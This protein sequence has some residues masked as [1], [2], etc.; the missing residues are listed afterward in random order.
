MD[1]RM[2]GI[3]WIQRWMDDAVGAEDAPA[4]PSHRLPCP[5]VPFSAVLCQHLPEGTDCERLVGSSAVYRVCFGTAC[6]HLAQAALLL[7]VRSSAGRRAQIHNGYGDRDRHR[8]RGWA[9]GAAEGPVTLALAAPQMLAPEAAGA[10]GALCRQLLPPRGRLHPRCVPHP[11]Q[12]GTLGTHCAPCA[13]PTAALS[14]AWHYTGVCGGFAFILI[15]LVLITAFAHTWNK[16]WWVLG[17]LCW[18]RGGVLGCWAECQVP[19]RC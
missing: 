6:F 8:A 2:N 3:D 16:N 19:G 4:G 9:G 10:G 18:V 12:A 14:P 13:G 5:Q 17:G 11:A 15:Q 1:G 7:N